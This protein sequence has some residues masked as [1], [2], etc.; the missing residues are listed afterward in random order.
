MKIDTKNTEVHINS[1][2]VRKSIGLT[3]AKDSLEI[4]T[5]KAQ[6][7]VDDATRNYVEMGKQMSN[8]ADGVTIGKIVKQKMLEQPEMY[9]AFLPNA[10][11]EISWEPSSV[12]Y[13]FTPSESNY[14]WQMAQNQFNYIPGSVK[15]TIL[16]KASVEIEYL[17]GPQYVPKSAS[18]DYEAE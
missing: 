4:R 18:P 16:Q 7:S 5:Q 13:D 3:N 10:S 2:E 9:T 6:Q 12:S 1:Y 11:A 15:M 14:N 17:G 8:T